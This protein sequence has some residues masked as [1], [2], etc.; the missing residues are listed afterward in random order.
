MLQW[1]VMNAQF[2]VT[3]TMYTSEALGISMADFSQEKIPFMQEL[4]IHFH[5]K[6]NPYLYFGVALPSHEL[7]FALQSLN[8]KLASSK[9]FSFALIWCSQNMG[10]SAWT[11][12]QHL[13]SA[14][15]CMPRG[16]QNLC[17]NFTGKR[18]VENFF[19]MWVTILLTVHG[20]C[21][22]KS[23]W[24]AQVNTVHLK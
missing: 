7:G 24:N 12:G 4:R 16:T 2:H 8:L 3:D 9:V 20:I 1:T 17:K 13:P 11:A 18:N 14:K 5:F 6:V 19:K 21:L 15:P 23:Q 22:Q 10:C